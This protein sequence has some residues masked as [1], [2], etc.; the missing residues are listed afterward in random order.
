M[1]N[2]SAAGVDVGRD[3]LDV[4]I[5]PSGRHF[6]LANTPAAIAGL[7]ARLKRCGV[8]RVVLASTGA[9]AARLP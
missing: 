2:A 7:P 9:P 3:W 1:T 8:D 6:R 4:A 5:A